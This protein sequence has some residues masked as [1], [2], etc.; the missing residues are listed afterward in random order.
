MWVIGHRKNGPGSGVHILMVYILLYWTIKP[1]GLPFIVSL[2]LKT[3]SVLG[4]LSSFAGILLGT[5]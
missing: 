4:L 2:G 1:N 3:I 5:H